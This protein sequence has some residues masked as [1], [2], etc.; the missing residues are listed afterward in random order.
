VR[1]FIKLIRVKHYIKNG[2]IFFPL[3]FARRF[4]E[5]T[6]FIDVSI[7]FVSFSLMASVVYIINDINDI[8]KDLNH[9]TKRYRPLVTGKIKVSAALIISVVLF[10]SSIS[11][12]LQF[13]NYW[14]LVILVIYLSSNLLYT[15]WIKDIPIIEL[16]V[17][18]LGFM[19]RLLI[20]G[21][22]INVPISEWLFLTVLSMSFYLAIGKRKGELNKSTEHS[23]IVLQQYS[24]KYLD[25]FLYVFLTMT[26][27]F[28]SLWSSAINESSFLASGL[29]IWTVP[30]VIVIVMR[31]SFIIEGDSMGDP[32]EVLFSDLLL[33]GLVLFYITMMFIIIY[34]QLLWN[35]I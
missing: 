23:R 9:P 32:A 35:L 24:D 16:T 19:L 20:G 14:A 29:I 7:A 1:D 10:L 28:Y 17:I 8:E 11:L 15:F 12:S 4:F 26:L 13:Q 21:I 25:S 22:V 18:V 34:G 3:V 31:Y 2:L 33:I 5:F 6:S 30:I 27:I